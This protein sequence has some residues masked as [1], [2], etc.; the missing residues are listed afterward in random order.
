MQ[1]TKD[2]N[3]QDENNDN[4]GIELYCDK[5]QAKGNMFQDNINIINSSYFGQE[6]IVS[7][8]LLLVYMDK[9]E[10]Y[11][12]NNCLIIEVNSE[13]KEIKNKMICYPTNFLVLI[14]PHDH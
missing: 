3:I 14:L 2:N 11:I 5:H 12:S 1:K 6:S 9:K 10:R 13:D 8:T 7:D 4:K